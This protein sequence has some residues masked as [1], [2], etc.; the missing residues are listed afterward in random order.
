MSWL[1]KSMAALSLAVPLLGSAACSGTQEQR[2][3]SGG[4]V[5]AGTGAAVGSVTGVSI[6]SG[7]AI[8][9][10]AG[11]VGGYVYGKNQ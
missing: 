3:L 6:L 10:A 9:A 5:G 2:V 8:G 11:A 7:A 1:A 4:A